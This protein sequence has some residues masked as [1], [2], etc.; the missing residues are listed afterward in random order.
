MSDDVGRPLGP[1][2]VICVHCAGKYLKKLAY[3][4]RKDIPSDDLPGAVSV[5][6]VA[7]LQH[8]LCVCCLSA[9]L[10][11]CLLPVCNTVCVSVS[12]L[13]S[14]FT[15]I[16]LPVSTTTICLSVYLP[17][18]LS[19]AEVTSRPDCHYGKNCRTQTHNPSHARY[20]MY[21]EFMG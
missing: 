1:D 7:C 20:N 15:T 19:T 17:C 14:V 8:C 9:T 2:T 10:S 5:V 16:R 4:Y 21:V 3:L 6:S 12:T 13:L 11:V 18:D